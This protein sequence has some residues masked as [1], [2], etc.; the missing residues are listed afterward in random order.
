ML[1]LWQAIFLGILQG[2]SELFPVSSLGHLIIIKG[3]LHWNFSLSDR[4]FLPFVVALHLATAIALVIY[5]WKQW[6]QVLAAYLGSL[7]RMK[8]VYDENSKFAW[9]LVAGTIVV[10][11]IG[12]ALEKKIRLFFEDPKYYWMVAGF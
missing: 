1:T 4:H 9:L 10:V 5:F 6:L 11:I 12:L 8:L 7:Q 3:L 2:V